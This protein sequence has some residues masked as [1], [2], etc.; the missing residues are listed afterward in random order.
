MQDKNIIAIAQ[1]G[2][3]EPSNLGKQSPYDEL[4]VHHSKWKHYHLLPFVLFSSGL[5]LTRIFGTFIVD[6][7]F[8]LLP[9]EMLKMTSC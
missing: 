6:I 2:Q 3:N 5:W 1:P 4:K 7:S 8:T 9:D